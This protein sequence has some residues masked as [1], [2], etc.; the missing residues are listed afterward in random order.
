MERVVMRSAAVILV[1]TD[2]SRR[3]LIRKY[4]GID[5]VVHVVPNGFDDEDITQ[6]S[7]MDASDRGN[8]DPAELVCVY[9]GLI[10]ARRNPV[11][12]FEAI[13]RVNESGY[14]T[15]RLEIA[16]F[17]PREAKEAVSR[18]AMDKAIVE[19]GYL[20]HHRT[21][22]TIMDADVAVLIST[23]DEGAQTAIPSKLFEYAACGTFI[24]GLAD[25][26]ATSE[27]IEQHRWGIV[28]SPADSR[29]IERTLRE[30][31][32]RNRAGALAPPTAATDEVNAYS[33]R[34]QAMI[35]AKL[36]EKALK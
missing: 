23:A 9:T 17:L 27:M 25:R 34:A 24:L 18:M 12:L 7:Q 35:V 32:D 3:A 5:G 10:T 6:A 26:G 22:R 8:T 28:C 16:G 19:L 14:G 30:L 36:L 11:P 2:A 4:P 1:P 15:V 31:L 29:A 20:P 33:R 21:L 13:K